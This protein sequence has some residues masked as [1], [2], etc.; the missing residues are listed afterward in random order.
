MFVSSD[1]DGVIGISDVCNLADFGTYTIDI[2]YT[3][4]VDT[5]GGSVG[6]HAFTALAQDGTEITSLSFAFSSAITKTTIFD[7]VIA[8]QTSLAI[9]YTLDT[10]LAD[11]D[12]IGTLTYTT[13][14]VGIDPDDDKADLKLAGSVLAGTTV[15]DPVLGAVWRARVDVQKTIVSDPPPVP[16]PAS[17]MLLVGGIGA[18]AGLRRR[19]RAG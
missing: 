19:R 8:G 1:C 18:L 16:L 9:G 10:A 11:G 14:T 5:S 3:D 13:G 6:L 15:Y 17:A 4:T 12:L 2:L 7:L